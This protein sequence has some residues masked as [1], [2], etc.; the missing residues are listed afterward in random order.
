MPPSLVY[1]DLQD[2][3]GLFS[4]PDVNQF[5]NL[6]DAVMLFQILHYRGTVSSLF[7]SFCYRGR[8]SEQ[9]ASALQSFVDIVMFQLAE[10]VSIVYYLCF[11]AVS[12][13]RQA[14]HAYG[15]IW[16]YRRFGNA[17]FTYFESR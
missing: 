2:P 12:L 5:D 4:V 7:F 16:F 14:N 6:R 8:R 9:N 13:L 17:V 15:S 11:E 1:T 10:F 3:S